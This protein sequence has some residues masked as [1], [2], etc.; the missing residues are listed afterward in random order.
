MMTPTEACKKISSETDRS[1][2]SIILDIQ[3]NAWAQGMTDACCE[4]IRACDAAD[5]AAC[6][7]ITEHIKNYRDR[8]QT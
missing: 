1:I 4:A 7:R 2:A 8:I 5:M 3:R 6:L